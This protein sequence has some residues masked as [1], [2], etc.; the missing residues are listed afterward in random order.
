M[1]QVYMHLASIEHTK[2]ALEEGQHIL[3]AMLCFQH[4]NAK[5]LVDKFNG[6]RGLHKGDPMPPPDYST[7]PETVFE[8]L[9][10]WLVRSCQSLLPF[11]LSL[12][13]RGGG[14]SLPSWVLDISANPPIDHNYWRAR[15]EL[16][17]AYPYILCDG[18]DM[19]YDTQ[20]V[21]QLRLGGVRVDHVRSV[22]RRCCQSSDEASHIELL[23]EWC[24]FATDQSLP[25]L[26]ADSARGRAFCTTML[27]GRVRKTSADMLRKANACD[28]L[29]WRQDVMSMELDPS[30][31]GQYDQAMFPHLTAVLGQVSF[32]TISGSLG[33]GPPSLQPGDTLWAFAG[34]RTTFAMRR[35]P[36]VRLASGCEQPQL[37]EEHTMLGP[38]YH[39][40]LMEDLSGISDNLGQRS[41]CV[42]S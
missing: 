32:T 38:C 3:E 35:K 36:S 37:D 20:H 26:A 12:Q 7:P 24:Q 2:A 15:I 9:T 14:M 29:Q 42:I 13:N 27:G 41:T 19:S 8:Q 4:L 11:A 21:G 30:N 40:E 6:Y 34:G 28:L 33:L 1:S 18:L 22:A 5:L 31:A 10:V 16:Y 39:N 25:D 23:N 17:K